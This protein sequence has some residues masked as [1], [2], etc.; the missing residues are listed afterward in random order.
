[1]LI[2]DQLDFFIGIGEESIDGFKLNQNIENHHQF[3]QDLE[4]L[5]GSTTTHA[6]THNLM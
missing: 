3:V 5:L 1:M 4:P 6:L 2:V